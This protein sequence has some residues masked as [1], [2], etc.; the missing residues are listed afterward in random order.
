MF[1]SELNTEFLILL[2]RCL[3]ILADED[4]PDL[5]QVVDPLPV[6]EASEFVIHFAAFYC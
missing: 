2:I 5:V 6:D 4:M 1:G 3:F